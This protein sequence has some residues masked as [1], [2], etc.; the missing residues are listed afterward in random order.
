MLPASNL[1]LNNQEIPWSSEVKYVGLNL[2]KRLTF[3]SH[4]AKAI[5]KAEKAFRI[6]YSFLNRK[7]RLCIHN[8]L[9][10]YKT[11]I[12]PILCFGVE[13]WFDCAPTHKNKLQIIQNKCLKIIKNRH[14]RY[15]TNTLH[16]ETNI[17]CPGSRISAL[18][19]T[20]SLCTVVGFRKTP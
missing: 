16:E 20:I 17:T 19:F 12:R 7:S 4:T 6:L 11:C 14:W 2:D 10:L 18:K 5:D 15:S 3:A 8:K 9:L 1:R 13:T